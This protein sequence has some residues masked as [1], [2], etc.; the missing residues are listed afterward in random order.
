[1]VS[2][3]GTKG[4]DMSESSLSS[5][6]WKTNLHSDAHPSLKRKFPE[7]HL[8]EN[9]SNYSTAYSSVINSKEERSAYCG[10]KTSLESNTTTETHANHPVFNS[11]ISRGQEKKLPTEKEES[12]FDHELNLH[13]ESQKNKSHILKP[14]VCDRN[15]GLGGVSPVSPSD[16]THTNNLTRLPVCEEEKTQQFR[17]Q[18]G[19]TNSHVQATL[20]TMYSTGRPDISDRCA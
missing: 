14:N 15:Q 13:P 1:M 10:Y 9:V 4:D 17:F 11:G 2:T 8:K 18:V 3:I 6:L 7:N 12:M 19:V 5:K 20:Q 16:T